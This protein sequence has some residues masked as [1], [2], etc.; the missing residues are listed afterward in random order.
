ML[1][2]S[3][4]LVILLGTWILGG[5][6]V[7]NKHTFNYVPTEKSDVGK[8]RV[9]L[10]F[11]VDDKRSYV[12]SGDE[13]ATFVGEQRGGYGIPFNVTTHDDRPFAAIVQETV[14]RD[15]EAAGFKVTASQAKT[16]DVATAAKSA[17]ARRALSVVINE[18]RSDTYANISVHHDFEVVVYDANGKELA[19][20]R[21]SGEDVLEGSLVNPVKAA[22]LKVPAHFYQKIH[23]L[24]TG[25]PKV[26]KALT[27]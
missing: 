22:K 3:A 16:G 10:L 15:L 24:V 18:F 14:Q 11:A 1:K 6:A 5:C 13:P 26:V 19:R 17:N 23:A 7:G 2:R 8:G 12:V 4:V 25:N 21:V 9:V 20:D 27:N